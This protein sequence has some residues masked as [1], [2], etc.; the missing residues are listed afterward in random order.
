MEQSPLVSIVVVVYNGEKYIRHCLR[1]T[2][3][4][5]YPNCEVVVF[6][7]ASTDR[8][9][10]IVSQEFPGV[11]M[12]KNPTNLGTWPGQEAALEYATGEY[13]VS[14]SVDVMIEEEFVSYALGEIQKDARIGAIQGKLYQY[15]FDQLA[16]NSYRSGKIIDTCGFKIFKSRKIGNI[17]HGERDF[18]QYNKSEEIFGV[19]GAVPFFRRTALE[20]IRIEDKIADPDYFWYGDD[21][22]IAWRINMFGWKQLFVPSM[23]GWHDRS[24]TKGAAEIPVL[25][26]VKRLSLRRSIPIHKRRLDWSNVRFTIIKNDYIINILKDAP[27]ILIREIATFGYWILFE[28][29]M[30]LEIVRFLKLLPKMLR[31]RKMVMAAA[32]VTPSEIHRW[33]I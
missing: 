8:T 6:D 11:K 10:E 12:V 29:A 17:G 26:Q 2:L 15:H 22:D 33:F 32:R 18:G 23:I 27:R 5:K 30:F 25:G 20:D 28:R 1:A 4:Q 16:N 13:I 24:T 31:R 21:L 14:L 3:A 19:E 7:N 9:R